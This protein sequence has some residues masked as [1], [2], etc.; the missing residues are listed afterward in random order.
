MRSAAESATGMRSAGEAWTCPRPG[1]ARAA[2]PTS[3]VPWSPGEPAPTD[4]RVGHEPGRA[5]TVLAGDVALFTYE[6]CPEPALRL[7]RTLTG[8]PVPGVAWSP[9]RVDEHPRLRPSGDDALAELTTTGVT[10]TAAHRLIWSGHDGTPV[11]DEWRALTAQLTGDDSWVLIFENTLTNIS[12][13]PLTFGAAG[14]A[15]GGLRWRGALS[16]AGDGPSEVRPRQ[17]TP[18]RVVLIGDDAN[19]NHPPLYSRAHGHVIA[20]RHAAAIAA[21]PRDT[22][23]L[24]DLAQNALTEP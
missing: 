2:D 17:T 8:E 16:F 5:V 15:S 21:G 13:A 18:A 10:A 20:F 6:Y 24:A 7:I 3:T 22:A 19:P 12:G 1:P 4:L 9:P 23:A 11:L 14:A